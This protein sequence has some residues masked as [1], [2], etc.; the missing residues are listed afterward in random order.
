M[1]CNY[2]V[3][4]YDSSVSVHRAF[5]II[6]SRRT[7]RMA[8]VLQFPFDIVFQFPWQLLSEKLGMQQSQ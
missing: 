8:Y 3:L 6:A 5:R 7:D 4:V 1:T 2:T